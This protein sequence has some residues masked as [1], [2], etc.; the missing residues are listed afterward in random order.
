MSL[1]NA[2]EQIR[3]YVDG[4]LSVISSE[5]RATQ[6]VPEKYSY[7]VTL[8]GFLFVEDALW[9]LRP[10]GLAFDI[11]TIEFGTIPAVAIGGVTHFIANEW[12]L[13]W[14]ARMMGLAALALSAVTGLAAWGLNRQ[15]K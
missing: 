8:W 7:K 6:S 11:G 3:A 13:A 12:I 15:R 10:E 4:C 5:V 14:S 9:V 1:Y 2:S